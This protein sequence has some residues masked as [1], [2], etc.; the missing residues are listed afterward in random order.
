[1]SKKRTLRTELDPDLYARL[2][3]AVAER[4]T[5]L[6]ALAR[7]ILADWLDEPEGATRSTVPTGWMTDAELAQMKVW[8]KSVMIGDWAGQK[9]AAWRAAIDP[10]LRE[11]GH[12][13]PP[14]PRAGDHDALI[15]WAHA[16]HRVIAPSS[17]VV[18]P[19]WQA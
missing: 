15:A 12:D 14:L 1:M 3:S 13:L 9:P 18:P 19:R 17:S 8:N 7:E 16:V 2:E 5:T 11:R 6:A 4:G 10:I